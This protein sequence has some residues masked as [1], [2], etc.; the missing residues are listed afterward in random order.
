MPIIWIV[1]LVGGGYAFKKYYLDKQ[2][3][4]VLS[5]G[6]APRGLPSETGGGETKTD[7]TIDLFARDDGFFLGADGQESDGL[8]TNEV[9]SR[10]NVFA[11]KSKSVTVLLVNELSDD[12]QARNDMSNELEGAI[13]GGRFRSNVSFEEDDS[14][15][16]G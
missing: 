5:K 11:D 15:G 2:G 9:V 10:V 6:S 7:R 16:R 3:I 13:K 4:Q 1:M 12:A 8:D 14:R